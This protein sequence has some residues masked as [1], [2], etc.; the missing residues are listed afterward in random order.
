MDVYLIDLLE[1]C[2]Y[3][4][5]GS[6]DRTLSAE[7][8][9]LSDVLESMFASDTP[10]LGFGLRYDIK[11][12]RES[13]PWLPCFGGHAPI[14]SHI[15]VGML[16]RLAGKV[17]V[18]KNLSLGRLTAAVLNARLSKDE[19]M[20]DW[21]HR[22]LDE[23]QIL[24]ASHDVACLVDIYDAIMST[25][26]P[27]LLS[28][29]GSM[30]FVSLN[31]TELGSGRG[32]MGAGHGWYSGQHR[33]SGPDDGA[34]PRDTSASELDQLRCRPK[35]LPIKNA[36]CD[37]DLARSYLGEYV[38]APGKEG[39]VRAMLS[40]EEA[41]QHSHA[42]RGGA[43]LEMANAFL[44][45]V[46]IPSRK[47]PNEFTDDGKMSWFSSRGQTLDH[48]VI[49]RILGGEKTLTLWCRRD[50]ERY[51][52]FGELAVDAVVEQE[53]GSL[54]VWYKLIDWDNISSSGGTAAHVLAGNVQ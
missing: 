2:F 43:I 10:K 50:K 12:L 44:F 29:R 17:K 33:Y 28:A 51:V 38:A 5:D 32:A 45:F 34:G 53:D 54:K 6:F 52:Y 24:Y 26:A 40:P 7:Q 20:S 1:L 49:K 35:K 41:A 37:P 4:H 22:P 21:G 25:S 15:D 48:P 30:D 42:K 3:N 23:R 47:Y 11:R 18:H 13:Y 9:L 8:R 19:Q 39:A 36:T 16:G 31:L 14:A 46:N 27:D